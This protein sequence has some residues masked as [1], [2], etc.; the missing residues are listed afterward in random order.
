MCFVLHKHCLIEHLVQD[1]FIFFF[2]KDG[3]IGTDSMNSRVE[4]CPNRKHERV[5]VHDNDGTNVNSRIN[6]RIICQSY[7]NNME[8][9]RTEINTLCKRAK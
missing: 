3:G 9:L 1:F 4:S 5:W 8:K 6:Q 2:F 7:K